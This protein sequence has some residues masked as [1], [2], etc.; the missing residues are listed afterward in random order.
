MRHSPALHYTTRYPS[1]TLTPSLFLD[2]STDWR[3]PLNRR[4][5]TRISGGVAGESGVTTPPIADFLRSNSKSSGALADRNIIQVGDRIDRVVAI[6]VDIV[7]N[8]SVS[9]LRKIDGPVNFVEGAPWTNKTNRRTVE[10][11]K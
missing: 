5:R 6:S 3:N 7:E 11:K 9:G 1:P 4:T 8:C 10:R 2:S